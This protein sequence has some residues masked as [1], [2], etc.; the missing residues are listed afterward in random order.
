MDIDLYMG[1][2][3]PS[4]HFLNRQGEIDK[5]IKRYVDV[6]SKKEIQLC[7]FQ[8]LKNFIYQIYYREPWIGS[9]N[10]HFCGVNGKAGYCF[11]ERLVLTAYI[12]QA[13]DLEVVNSMKNEVRKYCKMEKHSFHTTDNSLEFTYAYNLCMNDN[14]IILINTTQL[15][16]IE[17]FYEQFQKYFT[18]ILMSKVNDESKI[19]INDIQNWENAQLRF[20]NRNNRDLDDIF[21]NEEYFGW[22][23]GVKIISKRGLTALMEKKYAGLY[24]T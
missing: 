5:I 14:S 12:M 22:Y 18:N 21:T 2:I 20:L 16:L 9:Y 1:F 23:M 10:N 6:I 17:D 13:R 24:C 3:W 7:S 8:A 11:D 19:I 4:A 15:F